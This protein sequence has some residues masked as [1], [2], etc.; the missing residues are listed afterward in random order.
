LATLTPV[1]FQGGFTDT[2]AFYEM[3]KVRCPYR[4]WMR[5]HNSR[6]CKAECVDWLKSRPRFGLRE[7][8]QAMLLDL[9]AERDRIQTCLALLGQE[10]QATGVDIRHYELLAAS[11]SAQPIEWLSCS[12]GTTRSESAKNPT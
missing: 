12:S 8:K 11:N 7:Q 6:P 10:A 5:F 3:V 9:I 2:D 1:L 4:S